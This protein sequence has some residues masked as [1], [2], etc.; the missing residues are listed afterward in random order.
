M[1]EDRLFLGNVVHV[2]PE[3][4]FLR[5][6]LTMRALVGARNQVYGG[7]PYRTGNWTNVTPLRGKRSFSCYLLGVRFGAILICLS[8]IARLTSRGKQHLVEAV[9]Y[10]PEG[11]GACGR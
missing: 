4:M 8:S 1:E 3:I 6:A 7:R 5:A 2:S 11:H 9:G 10:Y